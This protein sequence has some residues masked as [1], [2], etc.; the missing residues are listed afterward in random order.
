M[1]IKQILK[2]ESG[3]VL[4]VEAA[5]VFPIVFFVVIILLYLGNLFYQQSKVDS[6]TVR[7]A[8]YLAA[9]YTDPMLRYGD[10]LPTNSTQVNIQPYRYLFG[11]SDAEKMANDFVKS[12]LDQVG[13]GLYSGMNINYEIKKCEIKN[14]IV[15]QKTEV[16][17]EY[18]LDFYPL[19]LMGIPSLTKT[20][21]GTATGAV[22]SSEF[23][24][25][26][27]MIMDY[28]EEFGLTQK[29]KN[30]IDAFTGK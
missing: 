5:Y 29:I 14:F 28:S 26:V 10:K 27:D 30:T 1:N 12:E 24:R 23:I 20:S 9:H 21:M 4:V 2:K 22:D 6:I 25:N 11:D 3:A 7:T 15:Y 13:T 17:I 16:E 8:E 19:R 18:S